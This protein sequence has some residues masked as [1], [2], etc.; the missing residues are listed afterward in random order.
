MFSVPEI[1]TLSM[2]ASSITAMRTFFTGTGRSTGCRDVLI[3][4]PWV[5]IEVNVQLGHWRKLPGG[6]GG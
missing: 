6:L 2:A 5:Y 4:V 3:G 1:S